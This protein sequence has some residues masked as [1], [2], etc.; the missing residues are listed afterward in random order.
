MKYIKL[1][2]NRF[3]FHYI[4]IILIHLVNKICVLI[5]LN[6][7]IKN[8]K[9]VFIAF[10]DSNFPFNIKIEDNKYKK[11]IFVSIFTKII[12]TSISK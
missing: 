6:L 7:L 5:L 11:I 8:N 3:L 1:I 10:D 12:T 9:Y 2:K 4:L